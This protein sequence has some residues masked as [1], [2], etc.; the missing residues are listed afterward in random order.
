MKIIEAL[1]LGYKPIFLELQHI[2]IT[3]PYKLLLKMQS[4]YY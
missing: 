4:I 3:D 1:Q 2:C